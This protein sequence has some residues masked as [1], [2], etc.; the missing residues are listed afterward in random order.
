MSPHWLFIAGLGCSVAALHYAGERLSSEAMAATRQPVPNLAETVAVAPSTATE[1]WGVQL[2]GNFSLEQAASMFARVQEAIPDILRDR[3]PSIV[4]SPLGN[5][6][7]RSLY[8]IRLNFM[9]RTQATAL[10]DAIRGHGQ[11]CVVLPSNR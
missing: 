1:A 2:A 3:Q 8:R 10:C 11:S 5:R 6:G 7:P 4:M 9:S